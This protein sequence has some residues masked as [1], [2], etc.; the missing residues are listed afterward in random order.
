LKRVA[1]VQFFSSSFLQHNPF[2]SLLLAKHLYI[3]SNYA[4][5]TN[6]DCYDLSHVN[7]SIIG[8]PSEVT[9][10][11]VVHAKGWVLGKVVVAVAVLLAYKPAI[12]VP[13]WVIVAV[14]STAEIDKRVQLIILIY[15]LPQ[16]I[17]CLYDT[18]SVPGNSL[19][20]CIEVK[21]ALPSPDLT[22]NGRPA[23]P[24]RCEVTF[25]EMTLG[26][27]VIPGSY[28]T[29]SFPRH[30][31]IVAACAAFV[32]NVSMQE[33]S[34]ISTQ[35]VIVN[36]RT[37]IRCI[38]NLLM[39]SSKNSTHLWDTSCCVSLETSLMKNKIGPLDKQIEKYASKWRWKH[40]KKTS[41][42]LVFQRSFL[43]MG[44]TV[45]SLHLCLV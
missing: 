1:H 14:P 25:M 22:P 4:M 28:V 44:K 33:S 18:L 31:K 15:P 20:A 30:V 29:N 23:H 5:G 35:A 32:S 13:V 43:K 45:L 36:E 12:T 16:I 19:Q 42:P 8:P 9:P 17:A 21:V 41:Q 34:A 37:N 39:K 40:I 24:S 11:K 10:V 38:I 6:P 7:S 26:V 27:F 3:C 2:L